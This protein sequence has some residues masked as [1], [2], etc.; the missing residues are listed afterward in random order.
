MITYGIKG[1]AAYAE[2]ANNIGKEDTTIN[3]FI[4]EALAATLDDTLSA[5]DL[6]ALTLKTGEYG[7]KVMALLDEANTS[8]YGNPEITEVNIG[9]RKNP[10]ILISG[11][12]KE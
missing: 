12:E 9:V 10:A 4:Y 8:K 2:H 1:I 5:D 6:V 3:A 11:H 7:V